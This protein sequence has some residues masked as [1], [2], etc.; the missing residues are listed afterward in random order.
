MKRLAVAGLLLA[1]SLWAADFWQSKTFAD[2][3][4]KDVQKMLD[5]SPWAKS[6]SVPADVVA[7][8]GGGKR[9]SGGRSNMGE[10]GNP[11]AGRPNPM[12]D[13]PGVSANGR[14]RGADADPGATSTAITL[15]VRW[16]S[17]LPMREAR[18]RAKYGAEAATSAEAKKILEGVE[19]TYVITVSGLGRNALPGDPE[20]V[21]KA[22]IAEASLSVKG[23]DPIKPVDFMLQR[24]TAGVIAVFAFPRSTPFAADDKEVEFTARFQ[25]IPVKQRF[26][27][28]N[29]VINGKL[30]L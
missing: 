4:D 18:V 25:S 16:E 11:D 9:G 6:V 13:Q 17:A 29:M 27:L 5:S 28:K 15:M 23:K 19:S 21:K 2:W 12:E 20:A 24:S 10:I 7:P 22:V 14:V 26:Q 30:E 3:S 8:S 1:A